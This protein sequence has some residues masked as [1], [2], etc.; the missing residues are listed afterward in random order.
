MLLK[1][2]TYRKQLRHD[3]AVKLVKKTLRLIPNYSKSLVLLARLTTRPIDF[4]ANK[5]AMK[6][7]DKALEG[8]PQSDGAW[9][10]K[11][12]IYIRL[13]EIKRAERCFVEALKINPKNKQARDLLQGIRNDL[14]RSKQKRVEVPEGTPNFLNLKIR[15]EKFSKQRGFDPIAFQPLDRDNMVY[16]HLDG[17]D[18][19]DDPKTHCWV[20]KETYEKLKSGTGVKAQKPRA[21]SSEKKQFPPL[22]GMGVVL[23]TAQKNIVEGKRDEQIGSYVGMLSI[24]ELIELQIDFVSFYHM[25]L[26]HYNISEPIN[27][28]LENAKKLTGYAKNDAKAFDIFNRG[29][30]S[31]SIALIS[32]ATELAPQYQMY[33]M[34]LID[35][36]KQQGN[37][38]RV[39]E[40]VKKLHEIENEYK[41]PL[42]VINKVT[43]SYNSM[44][45]NWKNNSVFSQFTQDR[46]IFAQM[47]ELTSELS[48]WLKEGKCL[49]STKELTSKLED[50]QICFEWM[51]ILASLAYFTVKNNISVENLTCPLK[52]SIET[53]L[54]F[55]PESLPPIQTPNFLSPAR[56]KNKW[57]EILGMDAFTF[58]SM[59]SIK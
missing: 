35:M 16:V 48:K 26:N 25:I 40:I 37:Q 24:K 23:F 29:L 9:D 43:N 22:L 33:W 44:V 30:E 6:M 41:D 21:K 12:L 49:M 2:E 34:K 15:K 31:K 13:R 14:V 36:Y 51:S 27:E 28:T 4:K 1:A 59:E 11:G 18:E 56:R 32:Q 46:D 17:N 50:S 10:I 8:E 19:N 5:K 57:M 55:V 45:E 58:R 54:G 20:S 47:I 42:A 3:K 38:A 52:D 53:L 39:S 7:V